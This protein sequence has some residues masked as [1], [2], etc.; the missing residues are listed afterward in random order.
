MQ[1]TRHQFT[2]L[3]QIRDLPGFA[4]VKAA[5]RASPLP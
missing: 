3:K 1:P 4:V 5:N 2:V